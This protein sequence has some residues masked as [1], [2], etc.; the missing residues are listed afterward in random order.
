[1]P[2]SIQVS[3]AFDHGD[4][5]I[6]R[7]NPSAAF[8]NEAGSYDVY[9][10]ATVE[11]EERRQFCGTVTVTANERILLQCSIDNLRPAVGETVTIMGRHQTA[12]PNVRLTIDHGDG[13]SEEASTSYAVY[14]SPG[15]YN[16]Y[17][18]ARRGS[19]EPSTLFCGTVR[20]SGQHVCST[21]GYLN[22]TQ[23]QAA[24]LATSRS[25][26]WRIV[27]EPGDSQYRSD[28]VNFR[29]NSHGRVDNVTLG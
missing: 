17:L 22:L 26:S 5:T 19:E 21:E 20:V 18:S 27:G 10:L 2:S 7:R 15:D 23:Q 25:C 9:V 29:L 24:D 1:M 16:V 13:F 4:G 8:Y 6:D 11:G 28:R 3:Y 14:R 12:D